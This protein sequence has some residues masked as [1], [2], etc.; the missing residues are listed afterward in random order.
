MSEFIIDYESWGSRLVFTQM[1]ARHI[2]E[3]DA[4]NKVYVI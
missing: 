2:N 4:Y 1:N 3:P